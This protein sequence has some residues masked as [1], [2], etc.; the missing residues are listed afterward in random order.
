[1][2]P[3]VVS[4]MTALSRDRVIIGKPWTSVIEPAATSTI[5]EAVAAMRVEKARWRSPPSL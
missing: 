2:R 1:M 5:H 4:A 3:V